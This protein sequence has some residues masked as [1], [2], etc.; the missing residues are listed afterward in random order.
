MYMYIKYCLISIL[1]KI[2][3]L[4]CSINKLVSENITEKVFK[5][6]DLFVLIQCNNKTYRSM[7]K[8]NENKPVWNEQYVFNEKFNNK[9]LKIKLKLCDADKA[10]KSEVLY[11]DELFIRKGIKYEKKVLSGVETEWKFVELITNEEKE[12]LNEKCNKLEKYGKNLEGKIEELEKNNSALF[13]DNEELKNLNILLEDMKIDLQN[14]NSLQESNNN[15][16]KEEIKILNNEY[17]ILKNEYANL[18]NSYLNIR[19]KIRRV[20]EELGTVEC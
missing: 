17:A 8:W 14:K 6:N 20:M 10:G 15:K 12:V 4:L 18:N 1:Y 11:T 2:T 3:M 9:N 5:K 19:E 13:N 7:V 16:L